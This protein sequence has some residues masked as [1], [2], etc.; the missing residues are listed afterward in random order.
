MSYNFFSDLYQPANNPEN[1]DFDDLDEIDNPFIQSMIT[2]TRI[3]TVQHT[4][5]KDD[6]SLSPPQ[7]KSFTDLWKKNKK[8]YVDTFAPSHSFK[9]RYQQDPKKM[10]DRVLDK[11]FLPENNNENQ[12]GYELIIEPYPYPNPKPDKNKPK[13]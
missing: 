8:E 2:E 10:I 9:G 12:R 13:I 3:S 7:E 6:K 1:G 5:N 11:I 4:S